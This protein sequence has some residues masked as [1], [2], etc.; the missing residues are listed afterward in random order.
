[1]Y[2][3]EDILNHDIALDESNECGL[4]NRE[5]LR[6]DVEWAIKS[7]KDRKVPP[8]DGVTAEMM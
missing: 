4:Q 6:C 3:K 5:P 1:M 2:K 8:C 7:L